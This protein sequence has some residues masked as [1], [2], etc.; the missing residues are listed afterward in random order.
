MAGRDWLAL[1]PLALAGAAAAPA[2]A[3]STPTLRDRIDRFTAA[4]QHGYAAC[5]QHIALENRW[6]AFLHAAPG[7]SVTACAR[8]LRS[9][10]DADGTAL[11]AALRRHKKAQAALRA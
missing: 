11:E 7:R 3:Q 1:V 6:S 10:Y 2:M 4:S 8:Y 9:R 5:A